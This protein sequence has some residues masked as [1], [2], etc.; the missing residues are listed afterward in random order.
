MFMFCSDREFEFSDSALQSHQILLQLRLFV[1]QLSNLALKFHIF[2]F[3]LSQILLQ[4]IFHPEYLWN[5]CKLL[6]FALRFVMSCVLPLTCGW[7][8]S[9]T[10]L[11]PVWAFE[12]LVCCNTH[13]RVHF[14]RSPI[15]LKL[16]KYL[17]QVDSV[18]S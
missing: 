6:T 12:L 3:L 7:E 11:S 15:R 8:H 4:F 1:L 2:W 13:H 10:A 17:L 9:L 5:S 14:S 18:L 16:S